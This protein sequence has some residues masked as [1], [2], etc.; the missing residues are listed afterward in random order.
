VRVGVS[1][2]GSA[3]HRGDHVRAGRPLD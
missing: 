3:S 1:S 2:C